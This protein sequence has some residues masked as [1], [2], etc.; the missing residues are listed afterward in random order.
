[1]RVTLWTTTAFH[2]DTPNITPDP[3][4]VA[5]EMSVYSRSVDY[6]MCNPPLFYPS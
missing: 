2:L 6:L 1:M 5:V 4:P 3:P